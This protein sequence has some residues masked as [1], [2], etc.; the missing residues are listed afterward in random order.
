[1]ADGGAADGGAGGGGGGAGGGPGGGGGG[2]AAA[3]GRTAGAAGAGAGGGR[4]GTLALLLISWIAPESAKRSSGKVSERNFTRT[5]PVRSA[6]MLMSL[7]ALIDAVFTS[8]AC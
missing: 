6:R 7:W 5:S 4:S 2:G 1:M 8:S 3:G